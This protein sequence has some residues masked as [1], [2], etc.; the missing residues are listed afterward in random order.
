[1]VATRR[2][3]KSSCA[4]ALAVALLMVPG[5][6][7]L[8]GSATETESQPFTVTSVRLPYADCGN[9]QKVGS[10][11][12]ATVGQGADKGDA[13]ICYDIN[14]KTAK[15]IVEASDSEA[16]GWFVAND[17]WLVW[18][19][20]LELFAQSVATGERQVLSSSRDLYAPALNGDLVAWDDLTPS[21]THQIVL[22][23]LKSQETT[24]VAPLVLPDLYNNF[25]SWNGS[26]LVWTDVI[27]GAGYYNVLD[28]AT[29]GKEGYILSDGVF[30]Y[31]GYAQEV[32]GR[33][34]SVNFTSTDEW[35]WNAQQLGYYSIE[36]RRFVPIVEDGFIANYFRIA[37]NLLVI[38]DRNGKLTVQ[39]IDQKHGQ[40]QEY[41]PLREA[42]DFVKTSSD[43]TIIAWK[44]SSGA[45]GTCDLFLIE[46]R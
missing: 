3:W 44:G 46:R 19:V 33:I 21:R 39:L 10:S 31:P 7:K 22:R 27:D 34:Y 18:N 12:Y 42:V 20:G 37:D 8:S 40:Q 45:P 36:E 5:C 25:P 32:G 28:T 23:N 1:M 38:V 43:G 14:S 16:I 9:P 26:R 35:D 13:L 11:I 41:A 2:L 24:V 6:G 15:I 29:G 17:S 30:R 4:V